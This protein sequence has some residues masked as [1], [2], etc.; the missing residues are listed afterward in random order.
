M[1]RFEIT[2][3]GFGE[4]AEEYYPDREYS[5]AVRLFNRDL[6]LTRGLWDAL[7]KQGYKD[8][9]RIFTRA[10]VKVI[11]KFLGEP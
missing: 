3:Y 8:G 6:H 11:V 1:A 2:T 9:D 4:L 5:T 7:R 10:Q